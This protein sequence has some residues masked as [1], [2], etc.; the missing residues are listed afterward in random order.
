MLRIWLN[1]SYN[2]LKHFVQ[3]KYQTAIKVS[4]D[5]AISA[6]R[7][8]RSQVPL[9]CSRLSMKFY[10]YKSVS[11]CLAARCLV[12]DGS[13]RFVRLTDDLKWSPKRS[14]SKFGLNVNEELM[15][16]SVLHMF[17]CRS[18]GS[19]LRNKN[20]KICKIQSKN[21]VWKKKRELCRVRS[22]WLLF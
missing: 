10:L 4:A 3:G 19:P 8:D 14:T 20:M 6:S 7:S 1:T 2:R 9:E 15:N 16:N 12:L 13:I 5:F 11:M 18:R 17:S 21:K 22:A